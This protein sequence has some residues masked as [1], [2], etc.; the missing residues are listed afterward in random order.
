MLHWWHNLS[1][2][3]EWMSAEDMSA[4]VGT[5]EHPDMLGGQPSGCNSLR[6]VERFNEWRMEAPSWSSE[7]C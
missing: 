5:E 2:Y 1:S 7:C 6:G 4:E 3:N